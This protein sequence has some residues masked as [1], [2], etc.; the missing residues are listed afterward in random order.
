MSSGFPGVRDKSNGLNKAGCPFKK[1]NVKDHSRSRFSHTDDVPNSEA[2]GTARRP[3]V[4]SAASPQDTSATSAKR[5]PRKSNNLSSYREIGNPDLALRHKLTSEE[6]QLEENPNY[7]PE[8]AKKAAKREYNR[9]NAARARIRLKCVLSEMQEKCASMSDEMQSLREENEAL[10]Q[11]LKEVKLRVSNQNG[12]P[13]TNTSHQDRGPY[14]PPLSA[15]AVGL[16]HQGRLLAPQSS[17]N[18]PR[19]QQWVSM[20]GL[21]TL[22]PSLQP[23]YALGQ[24]LVNSLMLARARSALNTSSDFSL[25][26]RG[27]NQSIFSPK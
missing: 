21:P 18:D 25:A 26:D 8:Q 4:A 24:Q 19:M 10:K 23:E 22:L 13:S 1:V 15:E 5:R 14:V 6:G 3:G 11:E 2:C 27:N 16:L 17:M 9:R 12:R 7:T 20:G